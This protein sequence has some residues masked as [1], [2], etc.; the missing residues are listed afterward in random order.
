MTSD[1]KTLLTSLKT[2]INSD[3]YTL[4]N[5]SKSVTLQVPTREPIIDG[6]QPP[7]K[8]EAVIQYL[9]LEFFDLLESYNDA[10]SILYRMEKFDTKYTCNPKLYAYDKYGMTNMW[11]PIMILNKCPSITMF[12]FPMIK[13]YDLNVFNEIMSVLISRAGI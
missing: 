2:Y 10:N 4:G 5:I 9:P 8:W 7:N 1:E 11:R 12:R 3:L 6:Y 13:Y